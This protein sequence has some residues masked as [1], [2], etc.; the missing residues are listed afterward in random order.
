MTDIRLSGMKET[1]G[2]AVFYSARSFQGRVD[3]VRAL[4]EF[5]RTIPAGRTFL[6]DALNVA[7]AYL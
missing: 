5:A 3:M 6:T 4:V 2:F 7:S 1:P